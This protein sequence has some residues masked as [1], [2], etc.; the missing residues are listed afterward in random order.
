[1]GMELVG[2]KMATIFESLSLRGLRPA[3][4]YQLLTYIEAIEEEGTWH[5]NKKQ[6]EKRH[7]ELKEWIRDAVKYAYSEGVKL[8]K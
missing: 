1:M 3:H 5:G 8:P 2:I 7:Q 6:F 4:L